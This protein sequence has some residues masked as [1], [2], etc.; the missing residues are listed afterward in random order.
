ME[1][2]HDAWHAIG[3]EPPRERMRGK[4]Q[5]WGRLAAPNAFQIGHLLLQSGRPGWYPY[6]QS[7]WDIEVGRICQ[8]EADEWEYRVK[9]LAKQFGITID[10]A[11]KRD[12]VLVANRQITN[13]TNAQNAMMMSQPRRPGFGSSGCFSYNH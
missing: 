12:D 6:S 11:P 5:Y 4:P 8:R 13:A 7:D 1:R 3:A 10:A 2:S 9:R